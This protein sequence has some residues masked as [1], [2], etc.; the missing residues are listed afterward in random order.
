MGC[1]TW[2]YR[3]IERT[4]EEAKQNCLQYLKHS[5]NLGWKIYKNPNGYAGIDWQ[6][7]KEEQLRYIHLLNRQIRMVSNNL[8]Q[9]AVWNKQND[10]DLV[11]YFEGK[12]LYIEDT[13]FHDVFRKY[14]YPEDQLLSLEETLNYINNPLN[15]CVIDDKTLD[16]LNEFWVKYPD[17]MIEFG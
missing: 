16:R 8:C 7:S 2:F 1:H 15:E 4:Q 3:K 14:G 17:G 12:G 5:R 9:K 11:E 6:V 10:K 13:G